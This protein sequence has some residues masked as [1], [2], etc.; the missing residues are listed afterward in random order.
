MTD[1][2]FRRE[3]ERLAALWLESRAGGRDAVAE[4]ADYTGLDLVA[5]GSS[6]A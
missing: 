2:S 5:A 3:A 6:A 1:S 4:A